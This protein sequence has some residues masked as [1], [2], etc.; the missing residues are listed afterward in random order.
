MSYNA[1]KG[2]R[3][4]STVIRGEN[5]SKAYGSVRALDGVSFEL[6]EGE[7][8]GVIGPSGSGKTTLLRCLDLLECP[9]GG[10]IEYFSSVRI[11]ARASA[12]GTATL[13]DNSSGKEPNSQETLQIRRKIGLVFQGFNL[14]EDKT[15]MNNLI[16]APTVAH[17][18]RRQDVMQEARR[19]AES[20]GLADKLRC[21][22]W[23]LSGGQRQRIAILRALLVQPKVLLLDEITSALDPVLTVEVMEAIRKLKEQRMTLMIV[24]HHIEFA[25]RICDRIAFIDCGRILQVDTPHTLRTQPAVPVIARFLNLLRDAT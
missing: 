21:W 10:S 13:V 15:V 1:N 9:S 11:E 3:Q 19:L 25:S 7:V 23:Q 14:W 8:L 24:T 6:R 20:F 4:E 5:L 16:L 22:P 17:G 12:N 2:D 18:R